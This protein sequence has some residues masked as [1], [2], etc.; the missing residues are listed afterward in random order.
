LDQCIELGL[1]DQLIDF[2]PSNSQYFGKQIAFIANICSLKR[3]K[4]L[5]GQNKEFLDY[6]VQFCLQH[7]EEPS[8]GSLEDCLFIIGEIIYYSGKSCYLKYR[9]ILN[10]SLDEAYMY[11]FQ[12]HFDNLLQALIPVQNNVEVTEQFNKLLK[13]FIGRSM[14]HSK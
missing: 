5:L 4:Q 2:S 6:L 12:A 7:Y 11:I 3:F 14:A 10:F 9:Q 8:N 13:N 1:I